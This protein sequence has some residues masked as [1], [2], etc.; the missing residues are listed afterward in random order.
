MAFENGVVFSMFAQ[1]QNLTGFALKR[2]NVYFHITLQQIYMCMQGLLEYK[3]Q[4][5]LEL[6]RQQL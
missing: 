4:I 5:L 1:L 6:C 3:L 2:V